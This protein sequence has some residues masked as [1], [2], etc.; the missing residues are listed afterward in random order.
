[1]P[2]E[3]VARPENMQSIINIIILLSG[4]FVTLFVGLVTLFINSQKA[5]AKWDETKQEL[6]TNAERIQQDAQRIVH[7]SVA[8]LQDR[9]DELNRQVLDLINQVLG[10]T[11][12]YDTLQQSYTGVITS[13]AE[14][15]ASCAKSDNELQLMRASNTELI[16]SIAEEIAAKLEL[17][18]K[19]DQA[20]IELRTATLDLHAAELKVKDEQN[21]KMLLEQTVEKLTE[22]YQQAIDKISTLETRIVILEQAN[23]KAEDRARLAEAE[24]VQLKKNQLMIPEKDY[25]DANEVKE[26]IL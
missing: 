3:E 18:G 14:L 2:I 19:C 25:L 23:E 16:A 21:E 10:Q 11:K 13:N 15:I 26:V 7:Q 4:G 8:V 1:M 17:K 12:G 9:V 22:N 20:L 6:E 24:N 5:K